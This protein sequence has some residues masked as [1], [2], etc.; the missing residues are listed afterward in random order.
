MNVRDI[1]DI[2]D[3]TFVVNLKHRKDRWNTIQ[4]NFKPINL[5]LNRWD[6]VYGKK[7]DEKHIKKITTNFCN[8]FCSYGMIGCWLSHYNLWRYI[9]KNKLD[10]VL[11]L[12]DDAIPVDD[13]NKKFVNAWKNLSKSPDI[14]KN[15]DIIYIGCC[16]SCDK[17]ANNLL[18]I[19]GIHNKDIYF[20]KK[21]VD[22]VMIPGFPAG[23]HAYMI[24]YKGAKKLVSNKEMDKVKYHI[25]ASLANFYKDNNNNP[26]KEPFNVY[27]L[28]EPLIFQSGNTEGS[29]IANDE[30]PSL[31]Y[32]FS[33]MKVT[34]NHKMDV[35]MNT[36]HVN[37]R[38]LDMNVNGYVVLFGVLSFLVGLCGNE[39]V[40]QYYIYIL[41]LI[42]VIDIIISKNKKLNNLIL[43][44]FVIVV[45]LYAGYKLNNRNR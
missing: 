43:E 7:I 31:N 10:R 1:R 26:Q 24:S 27:A 28:K 39:T 4:N 29:D 12:E 42:N 44:I 20:N 19:I 17:G 22:D 40:I 8:Y 2:I 30:H 6:A 35:I 33:K 15:Y 21:R 18:S 11:V 25:D 23:T 41:I 45:C 16:G 3:H 37:I 5:K 9:V 36:Q 14:S 32:F 34:E 13:F 38:K